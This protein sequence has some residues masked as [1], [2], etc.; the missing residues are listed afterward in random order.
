MVRVGGGASAGGGGGG[1]ITAAIAGARDTLL[2]PDATRQDV[3]KLCEEARK[4][5][6][7]SVCVNSTKPGFQVVD[8]DRR[9][10]IA[11]NLPVGFDPDRSC[12]DVRLSPA[13]KR[14]YAEI[15]RGLAGPRNELSVRVFGAQ[16]EAFEHQFVVGHDELLWAMDLSPDGRFLAT[17]SGYEQ[18]NIR[19]WDALTFK[20]IAQLDTHTAWIPELSF[21]L[22]GHT[23]A[24]ASAD[25][26]VRLWDTETWKR[27]HRLRGHTGM[28]MSLAFSPDS[29]RLVSGSRDATVKV[30]DMTRRDNV[31][32]R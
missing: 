30:W 18:S 4:H 15:T 13:G 12:G 23:L 16:D 9:A 21:S 11:T 20:L 2:R 24:S 29:Q 27:R 25:E 3:V 5:R 10:I 1:E 8:V 6:F 7:A 31:A 19:V 26:T 28:V 14:L 32:D 17:G 22:D